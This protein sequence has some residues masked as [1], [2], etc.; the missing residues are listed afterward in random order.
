M[1]E[2][3]GRL[4]PDIRRTCTR[5]GKEGDEEPAKLG[6]LDEIRNGISGLAQRDKVRERLKTTWA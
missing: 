2:V 6:N 3:A 1:A 5:K 4:E